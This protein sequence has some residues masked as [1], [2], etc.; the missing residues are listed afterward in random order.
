M[1]DIYGSLCNEDY[2]VT[3]NE[4]MWKIV[5]DHEWNPLETV[6]LDHWMN[7]LSGDSCV[8]RH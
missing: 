5:N 6:N 8:P 2:V 7:P 3:A 4:R 1:L